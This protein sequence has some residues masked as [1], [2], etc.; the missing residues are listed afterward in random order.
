MMSDKSSTQFSGAWVVAT[1][2]L[3]FGVALYRC[4][5]PLRKFPGPFAAATTRLYS[6][7][8]LWSGRE[9]DWLFDAHKRYGSDS[10]VF[11]SCHARI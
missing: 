2:V 8:A 11:R 7:R 4:Y 3:I 1:S 9:H 5:Y 6:V 10:S